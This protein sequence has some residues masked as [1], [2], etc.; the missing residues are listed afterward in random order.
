MYKYMYMYMYVK[1]QRII[2]VCFYAHA[3]AC[4]YVINVL[5]YIGGGVRQGMYLSL[6]G[7]VD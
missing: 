5:H 1:L 3:L 2:C 4:M 7:F 6:P